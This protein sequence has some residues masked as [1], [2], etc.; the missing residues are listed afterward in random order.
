MPPSRKWI[1]RFQLPLVVDFADEGYTLTAQVTEGQFPSR[2]QRRNSLRACRVSSGN[3]MAGDVQGPRRSNP[4]RSCRLRERNSG[5]DGVQEP[6]RRNPVRSSRLRERNSGEDGVQEPQRK[7]PVRS[8]RLRERNSRED[9]VYVVR[10]RQQDAILGPEHISSTPQLARVRTAARRARFTGQSNRSRTSHTSREVQPARAQPSS[11]RRELGGLM[12]ST[13]QEYGSSDIPPR[14]TLHHAWPSSHSRVQDTSR[15]QVQPSSHTPTPGM[16]PPRPSSHTREPSH[17]SS[18]TLDTSSSLTLDTSRPSSHTLASSHTLDTSRPSSHTLDTSRPSSHTLASSH[19]LDTSRPSSHTLDASRPS[20][21]TLDASRPSSHTLDTSRPSSHT[22]DASRPSSH[23]LD[24][25]RPSSHTLDASRPSSHTLDASRPSSHTQ[26][27][28]CPSQIT[29][30]ASSA[31]KELSLAIQSPSP[32][33][34][35]VQTQAVSESQPHAAR[36]QHRQNAIKEPLVRCLVC[37]ESLASIKRLS[38]DICSTVCGHL[39]C[40]TCIKTVVEMNK[41]CPLCRRRLTKKKYH[42]IFL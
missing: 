28:S 38:R 41:R 30:K 37:L 21:H 14:Q 7:N 32:I 10:H 15:A 39:F 42:V 9:R 25:S 3:T 31:N 27:P 20:S 19:T 17:H 6:Q 34:S 8:S 23:T 33:S 40:S 4:V 24:A 35:Q 18:H 22:L 13:P 1:R 36:R 29:K 16:N 5:E 12:Q 2:E 26:E 11:E